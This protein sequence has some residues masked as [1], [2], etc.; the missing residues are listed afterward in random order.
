MST[1]E[2]KKSFNQFPYEKLRSIFKSSP[3]VSVD[4]IIS[5]RD[6]GRREMLTPEAPPPSPHKTPCLK[7]K[8]QNSLGVC[9]LQSL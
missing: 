2:H 8:D 9:F 3:F 1:E 4:E 6:E 7:D 5:F